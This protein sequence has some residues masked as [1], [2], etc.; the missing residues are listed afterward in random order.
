MKLHEIIALLILAAVLPFAHAHADA[1]ADDC[2]SLKGI[3]AQIQTLVTNVQKEAKPAKSSDIL[4]L[5]QQNQKSASDI[6]NAL[7]KIS[8]A[9][10]DGKPAS[11]YVSKA[12]AKVINQKFISD[13][14]DGVTPM[15]LDDQVKLV[16]DSGEA[17]NIAL[18]AVCEN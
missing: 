9:S 16:N 2:A 14:A 11:Q 8:F 5:F 4:A 13:D 3:S 17:I 7:S 6:S 12:L 10:D 1:D 15:N 18:Q